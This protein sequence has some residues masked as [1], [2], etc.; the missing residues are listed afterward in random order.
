VK[1][2]TVV[3]TG[4][5]SGIGR[6]VALLSAERGANVVGLDVDEPGLQSL[7]REI[8]EL[9]AAVFVDRCDVGREDDVELAIKAAVN[10]F[11]TPH[12]L[13]ANAGVEVNIPIHA[14]ALS[15]WNRII[16]VNL[17]GVFLTCREVIKAM[18]ADGTAGSIV[19]TSSP[20]SFVG[21]AGGG[22]GAYGAS[23][24]GISA[25]VRSMAIDYATHDIRVNAVVPGATDTPMLLAGVPEARRDVV[26]AALH[27][28]ALTQVPLGRAADPREVAQAVVWLLSDQSSYVTGSHLV[29]DGGLLA[30]S[31]NTF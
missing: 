15:D 17:T 25:L 30:K 6:A 7:M 2:R 10:R 18:V 5:A 1:D 23:K 12:A 22:N 29:C 14:M 28:Q 27:A 31:A 16:N 21:F 26:R 13:F 20:S 11:G 9:G 4:A 3:V 8:S 24:G 19:C